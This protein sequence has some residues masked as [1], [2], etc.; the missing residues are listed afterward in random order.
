MIGNRRENDA[1]QP[2]IP[3]NTQFDAK[4]SLI[5]EITR[6]KYSFN[7]II[8]TKQVKDEILNILAYRDHS[9]LVFDSWGLNK[10]HKF[11]KKVGINLYG[12]PGTGKTM[13]A[14]AIANYLEKNLIIVNYADI[15]SKYVGDTSKNLTELFDFSKSADAVLFFDEAD[16]MLSKRVTNMSHS[17]DVSVNQT[18]SV[19]L[20][21]LND[22]QNIILFAT[23]FITNFDPAFMR[24]ILAHIHFQ[25][26][27]VSAREELW[28]KLIPKELPH[29]L[30]IKWIAERYAGISGS[31]I[32]NAVLMAAFS[33]ARHMDELVDSSYFRNAIESIIESKKNNLNLQQNLQVNNIQIKD[34]I[35][36]SDYVDQQLNMGVNLA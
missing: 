35:V 11:S 24:R 25:L 32:S 8:L 31:D 7:D 4:K 13:V 33:A 9:H 23:N 19:L 12:D 29:N 1:V 20:M 27:D 22:Y 17:T 16:A 3:P 6:P 34:K 36:S 15:E 5:F 26:P 28:K 14:H 30:D 21:L 18:R 10:T 2:S